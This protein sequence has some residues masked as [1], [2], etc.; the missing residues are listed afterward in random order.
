MKRWDLLF[1][2]STTIIPQQQSSATFT[3]RPNTTTLHSLTTL[4]AKSKTFHTNFKMFFSTVA[5]TAFAALAAASPVKRDF[6]GRATYYA[7]GK[8][9]KRHVAIEPN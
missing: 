9:G 8:Y 4:F 7:T 6:G 3:L 5:I 2:Y 1:W